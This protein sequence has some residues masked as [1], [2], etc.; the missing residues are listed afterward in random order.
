MLTP[1][2]GPLPACG[3][4][5]A[6]AAIRRCPVGDHQWRT[7]TD[8]AAS[9]AASSAGPSLIAGGGSI[10]GQRRRWA[11]V[12]AALLLRRAASARGGRRLVR[13]R[14]RR[15]TALGA[16]ATTAVAAAP[17]SG[18]GPTAA[19]A[20][21]TLPPGLQPDL[22]VAAALCVALVVAA[23]VLLG[24]APLLGGWAAGVAT[25][26]DHST[27]VRLLA[28]ACAA[29]LAEVVS[30]PIDVAKT[31]SQLDAEVESSLGGLWKC[32][33]QI[34]AE[35]GIGALW[36][37]IVPAVLRQV[38]YTSLCMMLYEP[39]KACLSDSFGLESGALQGFL[40]GAVSGAIAIAV[41][42]PVDVL[43]TQMQKR[44]EEQIGEG[45]LGTAARIW[46]RDGP[47]GFWAGAGPNVGRSSLSSAAELGSYDQAE[48]LLAAAIGAGA[49]AQLGASA[50]AAL[51]SAAACSPA[52]VLKTRLMGTAGNGSGRDADSGVLEVA[53]RTLDEEGIGAFYAGFLPLCL[54]KV[55]W[56]G[57]FFVSYEWL[58][59]TGSSL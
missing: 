19:T 11:F 26:V 48:V 21:V 22:T 35:G 16:W 57:T 37:G 49:L 7:G 10:G 14:A 1:A 5:S 45:M 20:A 6:R 42:N 34:A 54:R 43:K 59:T 12:P 32:L 31:R 25:A 15:S 36:S 23:K 8:R 55:V 4:A 52:D 24:W 38:C 9:A 13:R 56:C 39:A 58:L 46:E 41:C 40:A 18:T 29:V 50:A 30:L 17:P 33:H 3:A 47:A 2:Q 51:L 53:R 28:S 44:P 27:W